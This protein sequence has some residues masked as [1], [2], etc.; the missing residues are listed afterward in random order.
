MLWQPSLPP[1]YTQMTDE[2]LVAVRTPGTV[3]GNRYLAQGDPAFP[4]EDRLQVVGI[5]VLPVGENDLLRPPGDDQS[6]LGNES[7]IAGI[8][9]IAVLTYTQRFL[10]GS[11]ERFS[12]AC[13][14]IGGDELT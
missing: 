2:Q 13:S 4:L 12:L 5:V 1:A 3:A 14:T 9:P 7:Q 11:A 8:Q 10:L 6:N